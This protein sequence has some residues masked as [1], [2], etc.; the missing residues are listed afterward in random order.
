MPSGSKQFV[1]RESHGDGAIGAHGVFR[2][3]DQFAQQSGAVLEAAAIFVE[4][5]VVAL[6]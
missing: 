4:P 2:I 3:L 6:L 5:M 1:D